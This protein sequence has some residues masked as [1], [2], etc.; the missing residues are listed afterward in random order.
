MVYPGVRACPSGLASRGHRVDEKLTE[1]RDEAPFNG[2]NGTQETG[3]DL[4]FS[5]SE[6]VTSGFGGRSDFLDAEEVRGSNPLAPTKKGPGQWAPRT[7]R[8]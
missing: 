4:R 6:S 3:A 5:K 1:R 8:S 2:N 7:E